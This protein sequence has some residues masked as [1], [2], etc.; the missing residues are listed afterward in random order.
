MARRRERQAE[1]EQQARRDLMAF[2]QFL[3]DSATA[4]IKYDETPIEEKRL[5]MRHRL[6]LSHALRQLIAVLNA[7]P[8]S[9]VR[10]RKLHMLWQALGSTATIVEHTVQTPIEK[11]RVKGVSA[12]RKAKSTKL[13][14][15]IVELAQPHWRAHPEWVSYKIAGKIWRQFNHRLDAFKEE[16][17]LTGETTLERRALANRIERLRFASEK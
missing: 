1:G 17:L 16:G 2:V 3:K 9:A 11:R 6:W 15:L 12:G 7:Q 5:L 13:D 4:A 10:E 14:A 8:E